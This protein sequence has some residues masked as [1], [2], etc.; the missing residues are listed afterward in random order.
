MNSTLQAE[1]HRSRRIRSLGRQLTTQPNSNQHTFDVIFGVVAPLLCF[2]FDPIVF[3]GGFFD[4]PLLPQHQ[5]LS[6]CIAAVQIPLLVVWLQFGKRLG[7]WRQLLAG[8]LFTGSLFSLV[9]GLAI[10]PYSAIGLIIAIG[11]FGFIPFLTAFTYFRAGFRALKGV[12]L[13]PHRF[14]G[15][16]VLPG[17]IFAIAVPVLVAGQMSLSFSH[18]MNDILSGDPQ[19]A[20]I[21]VWR[22][23]NNPLVTRDRFDSIVTSYTLETD[24]G[25][26][27]VLANSF[28]ALTGQDLRQRASIIRD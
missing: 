19:R 7:F 23:R 2:Y 1:S 8:A 6:Y 21:G 15:S 5:I 26:R 28:Q 16:A 12:G 22:L 14:L 11:L 24:E 25:K 17:A 3:K 18:S 27:E 9:V 4:G 13:P 10:L 20:E